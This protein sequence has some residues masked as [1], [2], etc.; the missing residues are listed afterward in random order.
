M[1]GTSIRDLMFFFSRAQGQIGYPPAMSAEAT[2]GFSLMGCKGAVLAVTKCGA[3]NR[4]LAPFEGTVADAHAAPGTDLARRVKSG[5]LTVLY[6]GK[7]HRRFSMV[8]IV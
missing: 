1:R 3:G 4:I 6:S 8:R 7:A 5:L 2:R